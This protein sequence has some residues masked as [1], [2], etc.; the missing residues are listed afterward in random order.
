M[1][2]V[3]LQIAKQL[4]AVSSEE[5]EHLRVREADGGVCV[6]LPLGSFGALTTKLCFRAEG[7]VIPQE[8][9]PNAARVERRKMRRSQGRAGQ[10][11]AG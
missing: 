8:D 1:G 7:I 3:S 9:L 10:G 6:L 11:M 5:L 4:A 2:S